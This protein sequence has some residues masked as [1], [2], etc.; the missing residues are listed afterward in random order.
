MEILTAE[1]KKA[2]QKALADVDILRAE[3]QKAKRAGI[4]V[5]DLEAKLREAELALK[6][7][8]KVYLKG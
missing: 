7:I 5:S 8:A 6:N 2:I 3:I 4:D 1:E